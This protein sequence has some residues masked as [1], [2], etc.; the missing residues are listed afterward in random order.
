MNCEQRKEFRY[1][2]DALLPHV[3]IWKEAMLSAALWFIFKELGIT[4]IYYH[5]YESG[6]VL[7]DIEHGRP[8]RS[9]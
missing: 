6:C 9:L 2:Q 1:L 4:T 8:P 3:A 7:K 5:S